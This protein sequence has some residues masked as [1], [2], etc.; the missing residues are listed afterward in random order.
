MPGKSWSRRV[1]CMLC[2]ILE[3]ETH[4]KN[5]KAENRIDSAVNKQ[6]LL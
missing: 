6:K 3:N 1:R 5:G 4:N 2:V